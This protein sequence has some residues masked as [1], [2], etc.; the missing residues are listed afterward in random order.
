M[1]VSSSRISSYAIMAV[2]YV[3]VTI[4]TNRPRSTVHGICQVVNRLFWRYI[5]LLKYARRQQ[6]PKESVFPPANEQH[7]LRI[8]TKFA[9]AMNEG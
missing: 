6:S 1:E 5:Y 7:I 4:A 8:W 3:T 2:N 9:S